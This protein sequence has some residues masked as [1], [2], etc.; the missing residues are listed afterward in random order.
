MRMLPKGR[1]ISDDLWAARHRGIVI[2]LWLHVAGLGV[3]G[4]VQGFAEWHLATELGA[5]AAITLAARLARTRLMQASLGTL[6]LVSSSGLLVHLSGGLIEAHFH[7]FIIVMVVT[8]YQG[9]VPFL[10]ALLFVVVHHGTVGV[11]D[12]ESVYNHEAAINSPWLWAGVHG[13]FIAGAA[14]AALASW[15][16]AEVEHER[17]EEAAIRLHERELRQREA[18]QLN[19]TVVQGLV[20]AKLAAQHG[21]ADQA[22]EAVTRTLTL[23]MQLVSDLMEDDD[24]LFQPGGLRRAPAPHPASTP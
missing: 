24:E 17:A 13:L 19:D 21:D 4:V 15:K 23:A 22:N 1:S 10:L 12:P 6:A 7:F 9:W 8:R 16:H 2:L 18:V 5:I 11:I 20:T 3:Y 14:L